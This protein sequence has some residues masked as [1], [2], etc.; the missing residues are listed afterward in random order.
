MENRGQFQNRAKAEIGASGLSV[1]LLVSPFA[2]DVPL[3]SHDPERKMS[4]ASTI[5]TLILLAVLE[6][7]HRGTLS[8]EQ[9]IPVPRQEILHDT[10][11]FEEGEREYPLE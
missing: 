1:S 9:E 4:S 8:L 6:R 2:E 11:V 10:E 5:K 7:M 3:L